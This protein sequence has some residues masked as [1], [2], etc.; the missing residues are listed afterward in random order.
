MPDLLP[1]GGRSGVW[2]KM[3]DEGR[4]KTVPNA[5][6]APAFAYDEK[7]RERMRRSLSI[8]E[9]AFV[10]GHVGRFG[11]MKITCFFWMFLQR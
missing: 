4:V 11:H 3:W 6:D 10:I 5:I 2:K 7:I 9:D 1:T 8:P